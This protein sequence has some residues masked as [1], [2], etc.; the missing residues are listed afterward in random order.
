MK[1][2]RKMHKNVWHN[3]PGRNSTQ[4]PPTMENGQNLPQDN[5]KSCNQLFR[6]LQISSRKSL[7]SAGNRLLE[8]TLDRVEAGVAVA[9]QTATQKACD[10]HQNYYA[11]PKEAVTSAYNADSWCRSDHG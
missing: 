4:L 9:A 8:A 2:E 7:G 1:E 6:V 11:L 3:E 5:S 10:A